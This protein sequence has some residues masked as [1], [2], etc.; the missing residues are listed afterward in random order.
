MKD[1]IKALYQT[2]ILVKSKD[3]TLVGQL[4]DATHSLEAYNPMCGDKYTLHL[5][6][7]EERIEKASFEGFGCAISKASTATL[8]EMIIGKS[9]VQ[10]KPIVDDFLELIN[11][12]SKKDPESITNDDQLLAFAAARAF[13]ERRT[14]ASLSW[15][16][17]DSL[18]D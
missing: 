13:P 4:A 14:C 2:H 8:T 1:R 15:E 12:E 16:E 9:L 6:L 3:N 5:K 18:I 10:I 11:G 17:L 7:S